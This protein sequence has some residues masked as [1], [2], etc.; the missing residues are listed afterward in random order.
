MIKG[1]YPYFK[2][3]TVEERDCFP[4]LKMTPSALLMLVQEVSVGHLE[5]LGYD[6]LRLL[7]EGI[8][9]ML[10][11]VAIKFLKNPLLGEKI[12]AAT[13]PAKAVSA[14]MM[15]E[16]V[17]F[18]ENDELTAEIQASWI[19]LGTKD[20]RILRPKE[21]PI[22]LPLPEKYEPFA[23]VWKLK[24]PQKGDFKEKRKVLLSDLDRNN[25]MNNT[26]Y[27]SVIT[28]LFPTEIMDRGIRELYIKYKKQARLGN[29]LSLYTYAEDDTFYVN[30]KEA[31]DLYFQGSITL[32]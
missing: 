8:V 23:E 22:E 20:K 2:E 15:R 24:L 17:I 7:D 29:V 9:F 27:A 12:K 13:S 19:M 6:Y 21:F 16:T 25:H 14:H 32:G 3:K 31:D 10:S 5:S 11:S 1:R 30:A 18:D 28:D 26:V 4:N